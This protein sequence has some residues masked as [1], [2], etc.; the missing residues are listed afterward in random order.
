MLPHILP[1]V[2]LPIR[3]ALAPYLPIPH[4]GRMLKVVD[5]MDSQSRN[6]FYGKKAALE[7]GD[8]A[9]THQIGEGRD[10]MSI[11]SESSIIPHCLLLC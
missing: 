8:E 2:P 6:V 7:K 10:I 4:W 11:L 9:V 3:T 5:T 1:Y